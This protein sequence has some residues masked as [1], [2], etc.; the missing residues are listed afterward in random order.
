VEQTNEQPV[1][2]GREQGAPAISSMLELV[3]QTKWIVG[4]IVDIDTT[5]SGLALAQ[6]EM[7]GVTVFLFVDKIGPDVKHAAVGDVILYKHMNHVWLRD[8]THWGVVL[9]DQDNIVARVQGL[10]PNRVTVAGEKRNLDGSDP[11]AAPRQ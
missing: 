11:F 5:K 4:R 9:D 2:S 8:G 1:V 3:P 7:K 10:D 6:S